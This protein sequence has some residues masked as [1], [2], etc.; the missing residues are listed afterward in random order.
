MQTSRAPRGELE[1]V[2]DG[3][4]ARQSKSHGVDFGR[5]TA[6]RCYEKAGTTSRA[7]QAIFICRKVVQEEA[8]TRDGAEEIARR[9]RLP[10]LRAGKR[11]QQAFGAR[12]A[13]LAELGKKFLFGRQSHPC[14]PRVHGRR[15]GGH[16]P[17][18][19]LGG[20]VRPLAAG[21]FFLR[22]FSGPGAA[23]SYSRSSSGN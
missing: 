1:K 18:V 2:N 7:G 9:R 19:N 20:S 10:I 3:H 17:S 8:R 13:E 4:I 14:H 11:E 23:G 5:K 15:R 12:G 6:L 22:L 21:R 16:C